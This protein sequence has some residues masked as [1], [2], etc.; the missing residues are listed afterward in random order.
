M[1]Q[2]RQHKK[3]FETAG[4][5]II[6]VGLSEPEQAEAFRKDFDIDFPLI[7]DPDRRLYASYGLQRAGLTKMASPSL[8]VKGI[9]A[10]AQG[11]TM[12]IPQ[13]DVRQL[14]GVFVITKGRIRFA[15]RAE[16]P[17]DHPSIGEILAAV[18]ELGRS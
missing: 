4:V 15:H 1:A 16:D 17:A 13:G 8:L 7:C 6:L 3:R 14:S 5:K 2:L 18:K 9:R 11:A 12:G 10:M